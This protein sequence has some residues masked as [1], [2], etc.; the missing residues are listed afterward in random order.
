MNVPGLRVL[1]IALVALL[2]VGAFAL[3]RKRR[4]GEP[5]L[6]QSRPL[7]ELK[8]SFDASAGT[9]GIDVA[10][11]RELAHLL[12]EGRRLEAVRLVRERTGWGSGEADEAVAKLERLMKRLG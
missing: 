8:S 12:E 4:R 9:R 10:L 7:A 11:G 5:M 6:M 3:L 1:F 2:L